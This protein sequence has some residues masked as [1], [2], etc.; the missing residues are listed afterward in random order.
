MRSQAEPG[1]EWEESESEEWESEWEQYCVGFRF[2]VV[3]NRGC[4]DAYR[5]RRSYE[6]SRSVPI[7]A[8]IASVPRFWVS[9]IFA[10]RA[11]LGVGG[12]GGVGVGGVRRV[13]GKGL[14]STGRAIRPYSLI[15]V[16]A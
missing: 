1:N 5:S 8:Y 15:Y 3:Q 13:G 4:R 7:K 6:V 14:S 2:L 12:V 16:F 10:H 11:V 9:R